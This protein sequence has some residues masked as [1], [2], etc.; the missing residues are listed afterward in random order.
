M[1]MSV[2]KSKFG[3]SKSLPNNIVVQ[4]AGGSEFQ[5]LLELNSKECQLM[6]DKTN[7]DASWDLMCDSLL[8]RSGVD[9]QDGNWELVSYT[10]NGVTKPL[11]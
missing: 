4:A 8:H 3:E 5:Q 2:P 10:I 11:H 6:L 7:E 9:I 1:M